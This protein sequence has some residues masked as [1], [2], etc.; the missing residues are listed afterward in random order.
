MK[1]AQSNGSLMLLFYPFV[2]TF[3]PVYRHDGFLSLKFL[4]QRYD[5]GCNFSE[6]DVFV[7][8]LPDNLQAIMNHEV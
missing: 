5:D 3:F 2:Q 6:S 4:S 1:L 7:E 8:T